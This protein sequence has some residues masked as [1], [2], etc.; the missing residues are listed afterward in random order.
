MQNTKTMTLL[1]V[2]ALIASLPLAACT[3]EPSSLS[4]WQFGSATGSNIATLADNPHDLVS[5]RR[6]TPRDATRRDADIIANRTVG[7]QQNGGQP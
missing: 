6:E 2:S 1:Q 5:P 4:D 7:P 3:P